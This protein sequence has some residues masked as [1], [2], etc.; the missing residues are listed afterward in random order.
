MPFTLLNQRDILTFP[1]LGAR[2]PPLLLVVAFI[3]NNIPIVCCAVLIIVCHYQQPELSLSSS[4][5]DSIP[6]G[7][8]SSLAFF[9]QLTKTI[10]KFQDNGRSNKSLYLFGHGDG[11]QGPTQ[12]MLEIAQR[13]KDVNGLP[14]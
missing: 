11:G 9:L 2:T 8:L 13:L 10:S 1:S 5:Y 7:F 14:R 3:V 4:L 12:D 6:K